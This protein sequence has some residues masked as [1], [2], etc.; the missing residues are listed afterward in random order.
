MHRA[1]RLRRWPARGAAWIPLA[2]LDR[3][4]AAAFARARKEASGAAARTLATG[5]RAFLRER[6]EACNA[7]RRYTCVKALY[8]RRIRELTPQK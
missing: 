6:H 5:Q 8:E 4:L 3:D 2:A 7:D 1:T